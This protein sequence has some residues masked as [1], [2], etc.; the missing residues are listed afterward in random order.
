MKEEIDTL[1]TTDLSHFGSINT[2]KALS[3]HPLDWAYVDFI[4]L[5]YK[6]NSIGKIVTIY[7]KIK[8]HTFRYTTK[9]NV[10][11]QKFSHDGMYDVVSIEGAAISNLPL[12]DLLLK[13]AP[14]ILHKLDLLPCWASSQRGELDCIL[15]PSMKSNKLNNEPLTEA[16]AKLAHTQWSQWMQYLFAQGKFNDNGTWTM[17]PWAVKRWQRQMRTSYKELSDLEQGSDR[18]EARRVLSILREYEE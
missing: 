11:C 17:Q 9:E 14:I 6:A 13:I 2:K 15:S 7:F 8:R 4:P 1:S 5:E 10:T 18:K 16:L 3:L 12:E